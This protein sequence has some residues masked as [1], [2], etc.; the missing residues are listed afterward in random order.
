MFS[1]VF[2]FEGL[3]VFF[4]KG[5]IF[6]IISSISESPTVAYVVL[7][8]SIIGR[9]YATERLLLECPVYRGGGGVVG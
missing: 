6:P 4:I 9:C 3:I 1:V 2:V 5:N 7:L 8:R